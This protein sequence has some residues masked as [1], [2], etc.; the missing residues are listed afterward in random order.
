MTFN[1]K[2]SSVLFSPETIIGVYQENAGKNKAGKYTQK[3]GFICPV[4]TILPIVW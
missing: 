3:E 1:E 2:P 4:Q